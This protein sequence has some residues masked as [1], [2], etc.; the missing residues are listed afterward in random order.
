MRKIWGCILS[1]CI[2]MTMWSFNVKAASGSLTLS[3]V[4]GNVWGTVTISATLK[5]PKPISAAAVVLTY[6]NTELEYVS[7][8][9][10]SGVN[11]GSG[12]VR[13]FADVMGQGKSTLTF[14]LKFKILK[15]GTFRFVKEKLEVV[16]DEDTPQ[17]VDMT[18]SGGTITGKVA[19][20][21]NSGTGNQGNGSN[22]G[23][24]NNT[25]PSKDSNN[26]LSSLQIYP[27]TLSPAF[28]AGVTSYNVTVPKTTTAVTISAT[29]QSSKANVT[30]SGGK[31]L[32]LGPNTAQVVVVAENGSSVAYTINIKRGE[33]E[34]ITVN[35][36][37]HTIDETFTDAQIPTGFSRTTITYKEREYKALVNEKGNMHLMSLK[38]SNGTSFFIYNQEINEFHNFVQVKIA[39]G[40]YIIPMPLEGEIKGLEDAKKETLKL[41]EKDFETWQLDEEFSLIYVMNQ[42]GDQTWYRYD[43]VDGTFQRYTDAELVIESVEESGLKKALFPNAYYMYAIVGLGAL[44]F[45]FLIAM[46]YFIASRKQ[47]HEGRKKKALRKAEKQRA[48]AEKQRLKDEKIA[49]KQRLEDEKEAEKQRVIEEKQRL[50][51][52][53]KAA[54]KKRKE[55]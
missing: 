40:K 50:K 30:V 39:E 10:T 52:E 18:F 5:S 45:I 13:Y 8:S 6:D 23:S 43:G 31:D 14:S 36:I 7:G 15:Q 3:N 38:N 26:K 12:S 34:K 42:D 49:E 25:Q 55:K 28:S 17:W 19:T 54:R 9:G 53:K 1:V 29:P 2:L 20:N 33:D 24:G 21:N 16:T 37:E 47:R 11:A 46:I 48:K 22:S 32:K 27:G 4:T 35:K 51:E 41:Q 44:C